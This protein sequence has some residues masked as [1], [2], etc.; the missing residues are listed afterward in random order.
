LEAPLLAALIAITLRSSPKGSYDFSTALHIPA[1]LFLSVTVAMFLG[2]TNSATEVLRDRPVI[3][4]ERNCHTG[5]WSYVT[6]K[7]AALSLLAAL[8][9]ASYLLV[10][11]YFLEIRGM[12]FEHWIWMTMTA[13]TGTALALV[14]SS[15]VKTERAAMTSVPLLLVPQMLLAGALVP[16]REMNRGLFENVG[17]NR[18]RGGVP[19]PAMLMPLR[20]SYE[21]MV[22]SQATRNPFEVER[23]RIQRGIDRSRQGGDVLTKEKELRFEMHKEGLRRLLGAGASSPEE[24]A[25]LVARITRIARGGT[26]LEVET[27]IVWPE[28]QPDARPAA[29][30]G[31]GEFP[32]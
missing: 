9:C 7:F 25:D 27:M 20:Y 21:A 19:V 18:E 32:E 26:K 1:Y 6:A 28:D 16:Y 8:Q 11:N 31:G 4:R 22:V 17:V 12:L 15:M 2:L 5:A 10:G 29:G 3:R 23:I 30:S 24:A 13:W 14:V